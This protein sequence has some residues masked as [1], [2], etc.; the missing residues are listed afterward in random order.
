MTACGY[1]NPEYEGDEIEKA[2]QWAVWASETD[3]PVCFVAVYPEWLKATYMNLLSHH[4]V[5]V[6]AR[7]QRRANSIWPS[8]Y[9]EPYSPG[10]PGFKSHPGH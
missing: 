7:F 4:N 3:E 1:M 6:V 8:G 2:L 10:E 9:S 5:D